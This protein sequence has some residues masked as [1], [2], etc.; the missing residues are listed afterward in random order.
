MIYNNQNY[1]IGFVSKMF[2]FF[3]YFKITIRLKKQ[4]NC[5]FC[6]IILKLIFNYKELKMKKQIK[7]ITLILIGIMIGMSIKS[8]SFTEKGIFAVKSKFKIFVNSEQVNMETYDIN[9]ETYII[10]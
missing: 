1:I 3:T 7:F 6:S 2:D 4:I 9:G 8:I 10:L 5:I